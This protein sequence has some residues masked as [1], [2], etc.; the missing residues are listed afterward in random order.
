MSQFLFVTDLDN[1]FVGDDVAL[2]RLQRRLDQHRQQHGTKIVYATGRSPT[3]YQQLK[4]E[5]ALLDPD[6]LV[7][8]VGT[9][10]Y[11][12]DQAEAVADV[13]W[14]TLLAEGWDREVV[15]TVGDRFSQLVLQP[16]SEQRPFKV[17]YFVSNPTKSLIPELTSAL[18]SAGLK[19][20]IVC[21]DGKNIDILPIKGNK[22]LAM[23]FLARQWAIVPKQTVACGDSGNDI[24]LFKVGEEYGII[25]GNAQP[26]LV[27][28]YKDYS[29]TRLYFAQA[30]FGQGILEGLN[31]FGFII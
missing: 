2:A 7:T 9:E 17:S 11:F 4:V 12:S 15:T 23:Q 24:D 20:K 16:T 29:S 5:K 27:T 30:S 6:A 10:I 31:H 18:E 13:K 3:L 22:G 26:E 8:S 14:S 21:S 19:V 28:W 25:V 1:T